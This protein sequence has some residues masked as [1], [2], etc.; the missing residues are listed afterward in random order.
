MVYMSDEGGPMGSLEWWDHGIYWDLYVA[1]EWYG[2]VL[3]HGI[4]CICIYI[5]YGVY[6]Y[7]IYIYT[8]IVCEKLEVY[9]KIRSNADI[10]PFFS[11]SNIA[12]FGMMIVLFSDV[13]KSGWWEALID[14]RQE[15][16]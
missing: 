13:N 14:S 8:Y 3:V 11:Q 15:S 9:Q 12:F 7:E 5:H 16:W 6:V 1:M 2:T 10:L 4:V